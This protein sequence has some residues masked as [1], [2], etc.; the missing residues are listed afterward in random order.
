[1]RVVL[2]LLCLLGK[3]ATA[4]TAKLPT[5]EAYVKGAIPNRQELD[6]FLGG[7]GVWA[8]Y[9][10][11]LGY[12]LGNSIPREGIDNSLNI[13]TTDHKGFRTMQMYRDRPCRINTYGNS[14]TQCQQVSDGETWQEYLAAHLGEPIRNFGVGGYGVFQSYK[15]LLKEENTK[16]AADYLIFYIWGDDHVRSLLRCRYLAIKQWNQKNQPGFK[17]HGNFWP[18]LEMDLSSGRFIEKPNPLNTKRKLYKM[19]DTTWMW[20]NVKDDIALQLLLFKNKEIASLDLENVQKLAKHLQLNISLKDYADLEQN[21]SYLLDQY[22]FA[23]TK[24]ILEKL[25]FYAQKN[26]KKLMI[27]LFDPYRVTNSLVETGNR[28]DEEVVRYLQEG[29]FNF[30]DMNL[31]HV[32][33]FKK[34]NLNLKD[35]YG[36]YLLGHYNPTG[37]HFFAYSIK[38]KI[39]QWLSPKPTTYKVTEDNWIDFKGYLQGIY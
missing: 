25:K 9:D 26:D 37:N 8:K 1:M 16:N 23:A 20:E 19:T 13:S 36:R 39:I 15:R 4:Q 3:T 11:Q 32:E 6:I 5:F 14:F 12:I 30:F 18:N 24:H 21:A 38:D 7:S 34:F 27:V 17:F 28:Y 33:D 29:Q 10:T 35:Y 22:S 2:I 31:I